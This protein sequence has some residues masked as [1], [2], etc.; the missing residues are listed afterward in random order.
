[1][2]GRNSDGYG[3]WTPGGLSGRNDN[4]ATGGAGRIYGNSTNALINTGMG[5]AVPYWAG[6]PLKDMEFIQFHPTTL[7]GKNIL[8][9]EGCRGEGGYL[10]NNKGERFWQITM[11]RRRIWK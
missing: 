3:Y 6:L 5:M 2:R 1:M 11:I 9:T 7:L 4:F 10:L 8:I